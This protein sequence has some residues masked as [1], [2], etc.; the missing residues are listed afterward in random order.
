MGNIR[1]PGLAPGT[2]KGSW[3]FGL[4]GQQYLVQDP[5]DPQRGW[6]VC[7]DVAWS[8]GNPNLVNWALFLGIAGSSLLPGRPDDRFGLGYFGAGVSDALE[9]ELAPLLHLRDESGIEAFY[10]MAVKPWLRV[11]A[12]LQII[13]PAAADIRD[14]PSPASACTSG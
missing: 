8:D 1:P 9:S 12:D 10:N 7:A 13:R 4:S 6:G 3:L 2:K 11:T 14:R 5:A